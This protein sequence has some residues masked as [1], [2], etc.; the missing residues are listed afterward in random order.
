MPI[1]EYTCK[2]C[3]HR[4]EALVSSSRAPECPNCGSQKLEKEF[5]AFA[6]VGQD[7]HTPAQP[8]GACADC[9]SR[10]AGSCP[11]R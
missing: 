5:S 9:D 6:V 1:Y 11:Y 4:F 7:S 10:G 8:V 2:A 3:N